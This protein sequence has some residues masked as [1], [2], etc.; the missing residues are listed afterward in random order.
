M[1]SKY[2]Q[3]ARSKKIKKLL[4]EKRVAIAKPLS[5]GNHVRKLC[6]T[7]IWT[8]SGSGGLYLVQGLVESLQLSNDY[9]ALSGTYGNFKIIGCSL[10]IYPGDASGV[11]VYTAGF[12]VAYDTKNNLPLTH[13]SSIADYNH[14]TFMNLL[15]RSDYKG[16]ISFKFKPRAIAFEPMKTSDTGENY[17][18]IKTAKFGTLPNAADMALVVYSFKV[19]FMNS[20]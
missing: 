7:R 20:Q 12:G 1:Q 4:W 15:G 2:R 17:G 10:K 16:F 5:S 19:L 13:Y 11:T 6:T 8:S 14:Y 3:D 18:Y 9:A